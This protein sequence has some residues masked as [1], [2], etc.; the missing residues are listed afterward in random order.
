MRIERKATSCERSHISEQLLSEHQASYR[1][2]ATEVSHRSVKREPVRYSDK[3]TP[4]ERLKDRG[5]RAV[6][7]A[8]LDLNARRPDMIVWIEWVAE[9]GK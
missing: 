4:K 2:E 3:V 9:P 6:P 1:S 8:F 7:R 5:L